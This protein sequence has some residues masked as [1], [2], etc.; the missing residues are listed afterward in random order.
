MDRYMHLTPLLFYSFLYLLSLT[1]NVSVAGAGAGFSSGKSPSA[2]VIVNPFTA[3]A[4]LIRYWKLEQTDLQHLAQ[5]MVS[6]QQGLPVDSRG[7]SDF[8]KTSPS[9]RPLHSPPLLLFL[10]EPPMLSRFIGEPQRP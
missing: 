4:F 9:E 10:G 6:S 1:S 5:T 8:F 2:G 3:K 7:I